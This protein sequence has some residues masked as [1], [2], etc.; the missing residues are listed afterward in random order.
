LRRTVIEGEPPGLAVA[1]LGLDV[2]YKPA[3]WTFELAFSYLHSST[4]SITTAEMR[5]IVQYAADR[6]IMI[7]PEIEMPGHSGAAAHAYPEFFNK[8]GS[9]FNPANP[10]TYDFIRGILTEAA[11]IF[12]APYIHFGGDEVGDEVWNGMA[13]V[14]RL[15]AEQGLK[16]TDDVEAYFGRKVVA[17]IES[18][19]KRPM[20]WDEQVYWI[21]EHRALVAGDVIVGRAHGLEVTRAWVGDRYETVLAELRPLLDQPFDA[22]PVRGARRRS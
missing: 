18:L 8:E 16:S 17:I 22:P 13:D 9:A 21:P 11:K 10:Q 14:D 3:P 4:D 20:A 5:E 12:P 2:F 19:G 6:H 15:K 1:G 7:V